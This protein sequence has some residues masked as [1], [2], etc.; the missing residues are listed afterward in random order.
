MEI[1]DRHACREALQDRLRRICDDPN[2]FRVGDLD[3]DRDAWRIYEA[4]TN[5][6]VTGG[7]LAYIPV[8][9]LRKKDW[10]RI[11]ARLRN[12]ICSR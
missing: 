11:D 6:E 3:F 8:E 2:R 10:A 4:G 5:P 7:M 9:W 1:K 12:A